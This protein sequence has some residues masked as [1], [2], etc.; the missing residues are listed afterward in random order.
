MLLNVIKYFWG[1]LNRSLLMACND[2]TPPSWI[3]ALIQWQDAFRESQNVNQLFEVFFSECSR[4][5]NKHLPLKKLSR[6]EVKFN[7]ITKAPQKS[8]KHKDILYRQFIR[9]KSSHSHF[10]YKIYR[11]KLVGLLRLSKKLYNRNY[12]IAKQSNVKNVWKGIRQLVTLKSKDSFKPNRLVKDNQEITDGKSIANEFN[13]YFT[14]I[15]SRLATEIPSCGAFAQTMY[16]DNPS[17]SSF[18]LSPL[19]NIEII[20]IIST[21]NSNKATGPFS[22]PVVL[23]KILKN[24]ISYPLEILFN[25]SFTTGTVPDHFKMA[26]VIPVYKKR[27][28]S[29]GI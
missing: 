10:K 25:C 19:T 11:N 29:Y 9:T 23:L 14:T 26:K 15:G 2:C 28:T 5:V 12:F 7:S 13:N 3:F 17:S 8:I 20:D 4:I 22:I 27:L 1:D 21:L 18:F 24:Y 6:K 16:L